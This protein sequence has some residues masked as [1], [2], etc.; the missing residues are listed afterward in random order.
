[1][2]A[3]LQ[4]Y[5]PEQAVRPRLLV[6]GASTTLAEHV[7]RHGP[8]P[9]IAGR[10]H[11][12]I[13]LI[14][15]SGL[16]GRGGAGF[17]SATKL[18]GIA[19]G[20]RTVV[21]GNGTEGEPASAKDVM[22]MTRNPHLVL[23]GL[24][25][26]A[27]IVGAD[28]SYIAVASRAAAA[29]LERATAERADRVPP[30]IV[31]VPHRFVAGEESAVVHWLN[32][33]DATPTGRRPFERGVRGRPTL[34]Q[35]VETL[36]HL[37]LIVRHGAEW[38]R[39]AG[40]VDEPGTVLA[41]VSG[42]VHR[43]GV[44]EIEVGTTFRAAFERCGGLSA[45][46][47]AVLV[48]GYFGSWLPPDLDIPLSDGALRPL[49]ASLGAR[50][51]VA[52]PD[53]VCGLVESSRAARY[54]AE[55]SAGQCGPCVFGLAALADAFHAVAACEAMSGDALDRIPRLHAQ[56][57]RRGACAHPDG[58]LRF[59][60]SALDVFAAEVDAHRRGRC[61][62]TAHTPILPTPRKRSGQ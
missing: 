40:L 42:A 25:A 47:Q 3:L 29:A 2:S 7:A 48:G 57:A 21:V 28:E 46:I 58:T 30:A 35:N 49:G 32:G 19:R 59:V 15:A 14:E 61:T 9:R 38:F 50:T 54:M 51:I 24:Q 11:D 62:A 44:I 17:P 1:M 52:L 55:E 37:A 56:I 8:L 6:G 16:T 20:K 18:R 53:S 39:S 60:A 4:Q 34:V 31:Q 5:E 33:G 27:E 23:D 26:A 13:D 41:T 10:A 12:A 45:P 22:L 43:P 36:A